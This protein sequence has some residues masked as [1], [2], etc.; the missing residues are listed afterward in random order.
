ME[1]EAPTHPVGSLLGERG[2]AVVVAF[3]ATALAAGLV[4]VGEWVAGIDLI[5]SVRA[6]LNRVTSFQLG[7]IVHGLAVCLG[8]GA[9]ATALA[10]HDGH[11]P[12]WSDEHPVVVAAGAIALVDVGLGSIAEALGWRFWPGQS[13][14][15]VVAIFGGT[16]AVVAMAAAIVGEEFLFRATLQ[17]RLADRSHATVAIAVAVALH[18]SFTVVVDVGVGVPSAMLV[19][20]ML[21]A[22]MLVASILWLTIVSAIA[23][24][25]Y[26][27]TE[28][29]GAPIAVRL[30][31]RA[32]PVVVGLFVLAPRVLPGL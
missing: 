32:L 5:E 26:E 28:W 22:S 16:V 31:A 21:V 7:R 9:V 23:G 29:I 2:W 14:P 11:R 1:N 27:R 10:I 8:T 6:P 20:P 19:A 24:V 17:R 13:S 12:Q 4:V 15:L 3:V 25:A 18:V 30:V